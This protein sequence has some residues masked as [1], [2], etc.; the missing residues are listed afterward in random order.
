MSG[1][2]GVEGK[3]ASEL[4]DIHH[5]EACAVDEAEPTTV[6]PKQPVHPGLVYASGDPFHLQHRDHRP[7]EGRGGAYPETVSEKGGRLQYHVVRGDQRDVVVNPRAPSLAGAVVED[8]SRIE[9][10]IEPRGVNKDRCARVT[11]RVN[12]SRLA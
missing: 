3:S 6:G 11:P 8:V 12:R 5:L 1:E 4:Q 9:D 10:G 7:V 2:V